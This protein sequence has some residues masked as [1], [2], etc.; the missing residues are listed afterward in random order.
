MSASPFA[1]IQTFCPSFPW[2][3]AKVTLSPEIIRRIPK[4]GRKF[5]DL[6]GGRGNIT[7]RAIR[8]GLDYEQWVVNDTLTAPFFRA[9]KSHGGTFVAG[10]HVQEEYD[11]CKELKKQGDAYAL[12]MEPWLCFNGGTYEGNGLRG[13]GGGKRSP[14]SHTRHVRMAHKLLREKNVKVT[15][16]DWLDCLQAQE[17]TADDF[18]M[19]DMP[20]IEANVGTYSPESVC[21]TEVIA[22]LQEAPFR[23]LFCEYRQP[24]YLVAFGEPAFQKEVQV[25]ACMVGEVRKKRTECIWAGGG[26]TGP[27]VTITVDPVPEGRNQAYYKG[28]SVDELLKEIHQCI[29]SVSFSRNQM[30][31]E[32]RE[33]LLPALLE[34]KK[35]TYRKKP[36]FYE[37]LAKI[38]LNADTVRQWFY[39]SHTADEAIGL[40]E[41]NEPQTAV[42]KRE[43]EQSPE[44]LLL[45]H[46]D[47]MARAVLDDEITYAKKLATQYLEARNEGRICQ[48]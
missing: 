25:R 20:Y 34:L 29:G 27:T 46:A 28:L 10:K 32:M 37:S 31:R 42:K 22:H 39:R 7:L 41:E 38:G 6:F 18:V 3:G 43:E 24:I 17:L 9:I 36:G 26:K 40:L 47:R 11:R 8:D 19:V 44:E 5:I 23:W 45:E 48:I 21:P 15:A 12:L 35:R 33:R 1:K 16:L 13:S 2:V 4:T 14:E 30:S